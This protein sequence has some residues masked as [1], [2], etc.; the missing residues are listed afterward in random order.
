MRRQLVTL[1][2]VMALWP[3]PAS[4]QLGV[5]VCKGDVPDQVWQEIRDRYSITVNRLCVQNPV[6]SAIWTDAW[7][8]W[9]TPVDSSVTYRCPVDGIYTVDPYD[10]LEAHIC[11]GDV[12]PAGRTVVSADLSGRFDPLKNL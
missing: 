6:D 2:G 4:A 9:E 11:V 1:I 8:V 3:A 5:I 12:G 10:T 7:V